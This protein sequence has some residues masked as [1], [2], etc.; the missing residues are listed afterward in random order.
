MFFSEVFSD[1][2]KTKL[3]YNDRMIVLLII[4]SV[5]LLVTIINFAVSP[6]SSRRLKFVATIALGLIGLAV[7]V[8]GIII[9]IGPKQDP[10]T[11]PLPFMPED[12]TQP[13]IVGRTNVMDIVIFVILLGVISLVIARSMK[14]QNKMASIKTESKPRSQTSKEKSSINTQEEDAS[15]L[16]DDNFKLDL[17]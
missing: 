1:Y 5:G 10:N 14:Q 4:L 7:V 6:K 8:C 12:A 9:F 2:F 17:D 11:V 3:W 16:D 13:T 15:F